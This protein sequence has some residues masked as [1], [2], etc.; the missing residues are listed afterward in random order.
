MCNALRIPGIDVSQD[1]HRRVRSQEWGYLTQV[2][3][4]GIHDHSG[5][6]SSPRK[7]KHRKLES[8]E[9]HLDDCGRWGIVASASGLCHVIVTTQAKINVAPKQEP[10]TESRALLGP[11]HR[12]APPGADS[13]GIRDGPDKSLNPTSDSLYN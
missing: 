1:R 6:K 4:P 10:S 9:F 13:S 5:T 7:H 8:G 11:L 2:W 3:M 12:A